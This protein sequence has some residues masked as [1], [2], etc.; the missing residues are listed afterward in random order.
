MS[1]HAGRNER[2]MFRVYRCRSCRHVGYDRVESEED[3]THCP[4]CGAAVEDD[5]SVVY[6]A[7]LS[8]AEDLMRQM[9]LTSRSVHTARAAFPRNLGVKRRVENIIR[10]LIALNRGRP[11][12]L[13]VVLQECSYAGIAPERAVRFM[14]ALEAEGRIRNDGL[15]VEVTEE[16]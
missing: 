15:V 11:V 8:E 14:A 2:G 1:G 10:D 13:S 7:T 4:L 12:S 9:V 5:P 3:T 6:V 16:W